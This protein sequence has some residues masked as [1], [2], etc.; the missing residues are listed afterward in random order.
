MDILNLGDSTSKTKLSAPQGRLAH[1]SSTAPRIFSAD[2][3]RLILLSSHRVSCRHAHPRQPTPDAYSGHADRSRVSRDW[4]LRDVR[5]RRHGSRVRPGARMV[6]R[7][8][9]DDRRRMGDRRFLAGP[10]SVGCVVPAPAE[11]ARLPGLGGD[12]AAV[13]PDEPRI[14]FA[15]RPYAAQFHRP[16]QLISRVRHH[17]GK[18]PFSLRARGSCREPRQARGQ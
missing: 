11:S 10:G 9:R 14:D 16:L 2:G 15:I 7:R 18:Y 3:I 1:N 6:V 8:Y 17:K 4:R 5:R 13:A 12:C